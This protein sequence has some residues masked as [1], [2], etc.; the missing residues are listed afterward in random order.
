[1]NIPSNSGER[2]RW[3]PFRFGGAQQVS[4]DVAE[5]MRFHIDS[6]IADL[7]R[8][9]LSPEDA[10]ARAVLEFG[11]VE[12]SKAELAQI[13]HRIVSR[14]KRSDWLGG[15]K[16]DL[17]LA[18]RGLRKRPGFS[19]T[20]VATLA[21]GIGATTA[22]FSLANA[23]LL[24]PLPY[25]EPEN[26]VHIW[27][28]R[29]DDVT[30]Q[31]EA[32]FPNLRDWRV[33]NHSFA[34]L[35]GYNQTNLTLGINGAVSRIRGLRVTPGLLGTL[36]VA[37]ALG[38]GLI[39][40]DEKQADGPVVVVTNQF[41]RSQ[42][43]GRNDVLGQH[44]TLDGTPHS[45]VGVLPAEF[46]FAPGQDFAV[47]LPI[48]FDS[49][50]SDARGFHWLNIIGRVRDGVS[51][52]T[53]HQDLAGIMRRLAAE[54][55]E[56]NEGRTV[57]VKSLR[58]VVVGDVQPLVVLLLAA[59]GLVLLI[60]CVNV[61]GLLL[62][63]SSARAQELAVRGA[64]GASRTRM[65]RTLLTE[66]LALACVG[67]ALGIGVAIIGVR[68][69]TSAVP[70]QMRLSLPTLENVRVDST[71][72]LVTALITIVCGVGAGIIPA[73]KA[74]RADIASLMR[75]GGRSLAGGS[76]HSR[77]ALI[78]A[79]IALTIVLLVGTGLLG[80]SMLNLMNIDFGFD[81][82]QVLTARIALA[83][84][85]YQS[86]VQQQKYFE[87][88]L[89]RVQAVPGVAQAGAVS[90]PPFN[91]GSSGQFRVEGE[92]EPSPASRPD[93]LIRG[94]AGAYFE[95]LRIAVQSGR[96]F[97]P[98]DDSTRPLAAVINAS[99]ARKL[100]PSG[101]ALGR[102][103]RFY[104]GSAKPWTIVGVVADVA[105]GSLDQPA[106]NTIYMSHLQS[107]QNRMSLVL[108]SRGDPGVLANNVRDIA[109]AL[110][111]QLPVYAIE[112]M[113]DRIQRMP[114]VSSRRF[115]LVLIAAFSAS[116]LLLAV[117]GIYGLVAQVVHSRTREFGVRRALGAGRM[118]V[119]S[120]VLRRGVMLA[121]LGVMAGSAA[122]VV[123]TQF[124]QSLLFGIAK[125]DWPT[126]AAVVA[127]MLVSALLASLVPARRASIVDP[128]L[129]LRVED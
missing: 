86:N 63:R 76:G 101:S 53:A 61:A 71:V 92:V 9:G 83:G 117:V 114:E 49:R 38:R 67:G 68:V 23:T 8:E 22:V 75:Q 129:A 97:L 32:S 60:A 123:L 79:E 126:Y 45:I 66:T 65:A 30:Q 54:Y 93:A 116:A 100:F 104:A 96:T 46:H 122:A 21:L 70:E 48:Q 89:T 99:L 52:G 73:L 77:S 4:E 72:L 44:I 26:L 115:P 43:G 109:R 127:V 84:A 111:P 88:L 31:S 39:T 69:M 24:Q 16:Q 40:S 18:I 106:P 15:W 19:A 121:V 62:A 95:T 80:R 5:E 10:R 28:A 91:G 3:R 51:P 124:M 33:S 25:R 56:S 74:G 20:V 37:P 113:K 82:S 11:D 36:G 108:R 120:L 81:S 6:R 12:A 57:I 41:W 78:V 64:L 98:T 87:Q 107:P 13:D 55:P 35:D 14:R 58:D 105:T 42:L 85:E 29:L 128:V 94:V 27:E 125:F 112:T 110:D 17:Q 1:M 103:I 47:W 34:S 119:M 59:A 118:E 50:A 7:C 2:T 102:Q 90:N